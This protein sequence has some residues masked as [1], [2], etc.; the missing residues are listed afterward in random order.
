MVLTITDAEYDVAL[1]K[2]G[3]DPIRED[4]SPANL[5]PR[6]HRSSR[7]IG[8]LLMDQ[9]LFAGVGNIYRAE[10]LFRQNIS[11]FIAGNELDRHEFDV[12]WEDLVELMRA[13]CAHRPHR[14]GPPGAHARGHG[15]RATQG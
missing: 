7:S 5:W 2:I 1:A 14:H 10:V 8:S 12:I 4:A 11:P 9:H 15:P 3:H 13:G 6:V